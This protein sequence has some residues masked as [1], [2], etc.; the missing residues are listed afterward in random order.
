MDD[1][2]K[3]GKVIQ[4]VDPKQ[5]L[6]T[7]KFGLTFGR[8]SKELVIDGIATTDGS[9]IEYGELLEIACRLVLQ[10]SN[11]IIKVNNTVNNE[12]N[13]VTGNY[14]TARDTVEL[15]K[16]QNEA[17]KVENES[18]KTQNESLLKAREELLEEQNNG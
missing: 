15:L 7:I 11:N 1:S 18:F 3:S 5:T 17:L 6:N 14:K 13:M 9:D 16:T 4:E 10:V 12:L 8:E 2:S